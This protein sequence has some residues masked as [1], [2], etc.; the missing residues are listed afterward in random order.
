MS[1]LVKE[2]T[3]RL[4]GWEQRLAEAAKDRDADKEWL[5]M[6]DMMVVSYRMVLADLQAE[7]QVRAALATS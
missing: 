7:A 1:E 5:G 3:L 2:T 6:C 4:E